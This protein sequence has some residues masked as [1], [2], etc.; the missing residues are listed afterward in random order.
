MGSS[1]ESIEDL[2]INLLKKMHDEIQKMKI[3]MMEQFINLDET[4]N[5]VEEIVRKMKAGGGRAY[6]GTAS[7]P[8]TQIMKVVTDLQVPE[9]SME[10]YNKID[11]VP[12]FNVYDD[13]EPRYDICDDA[14]P[15]SHIYGDGSLAVLGCEYFENNIQVID[16]K[17]TTDTCSFSF[18]IDNSSFASSPRNYELFKELTDLSHVE[19]L[20]THWH[21]N[22]APSRPNKSHEPLTPTPK[23]LSQ[24]EPVSGKPPPLRDKEVVQ[25]YVAMEKKHNMIIKACHVV[26]NLEDKVLWKV[27]Y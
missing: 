22:S 3:D 6:G 16:S 12:I 9:E 15:I 5:R 10:L 19:V 4:I 24:E 7:Q 14:D 13:E 8:A 11:G 18:V 27:E 20:I 2:K 21:A 25:S 26:W 23:K 1:G 17:T